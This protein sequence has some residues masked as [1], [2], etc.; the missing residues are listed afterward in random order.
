MQDALKLVFLN[1]SLHYPYII[2]Y[3]KYNGV[4]LNCYWTKGMD[5]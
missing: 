2:P 3:P 5:K 4:Q 1:W